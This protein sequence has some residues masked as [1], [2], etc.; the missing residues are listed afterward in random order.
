MSAIAGGVDWRSTILTRVGG[1]WKEEV[2]LTKINIYQKCG[3]W[4]VKRNKCKVVVKDGAGEGW[5]QP[6]LAGNSRGDSFRTH[7]AV[8]FTHRGGIYW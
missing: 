3:G 1:W 8:V 7:P 5:L 4:C 2:D 6:I